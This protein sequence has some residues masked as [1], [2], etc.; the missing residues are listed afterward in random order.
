M[1]TV[2]NPF[3]AWL[4]LEGESESS[5]MFNDTFPAIITGVY[6]DNDLPYYQ[7]GLNLYTWTEASFDPATGAYTAT[8]GGRSGYSGSSGN[9]PE[10]PAVEMNNTLVPATNLPM[11]VLMRFRGIVNGVAG[12]AD[13]DPL[14]FEF[15][16]PS[17]AVTNFNE[18]VT[19]NDPVNFYDTFFDYSKVSVAFNA[20]TYLTTNYWAG[21]NAPT[22]NASAINFAIGSSP[23]VRIVPV[24]VGL[25]M[26]GMLTTGNGQE[27]QIRNDGTSFRMLQEDSSSAPTN[28]FAFP[29]RFPAGGFATFYHDGGLSLAEDFL[30]E[31]TSDPNGR[32]ANVTNT[33]GTRWASQGGSVWEITTTITGLHVLHKKANNGVDEIISHDCNDK[34]NTQILSV[35]LNGGNFAGLVTRVAGTSWY[36]F[37]R[38]GQL[39]RLELIECIGGTIQ[40]VLASTADPG[41]E[42]L[43][44]TLSATPGGVLG[45]AP[46]ATPLSAAAPH[47]AL[48]T[49]VGVY[50]YDNVPYF[51]GLYQTVGGVLQA[52]P[53]GRYSCSNNTYDRWYLKNA[54][55]IFGE[56]NTDSTTIV[57]P[58]QMFN[59]ID[60]ATVI[61]SPAPTD[62]PGNGSIDIQAVVPPCT[63]LATL[64]V[65]T[66]VS[67]DPTT[68]VLTVT[69][70]TITGCFTVT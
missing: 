41:G 2:H 14:M 32:A 29:Y 12:S 46:G 68:C 45:T 58:E 11:T 6:S 18:E 44:M 27:I 49:V 52:G 66:D 42:P 28:R 36:G 59:Y 61:W 62:N 47:N 24:G 20:W 23:I 51:G 56:H 50:S 21:G 57:G 15:I 7:T 34:N 13:G 60:T 69:K 31:N 64:Q 25:T 53:G 40:P 55:L 39:G 17:P 16:A 10:S 63:P 65:V 43:T 8:D 38:N 37:R 4:G 33:T 48:S 26:S 9:S 19:F 5:P 22:F 1:A 30:D 70:K 54:A 3:W 67:F 35:F